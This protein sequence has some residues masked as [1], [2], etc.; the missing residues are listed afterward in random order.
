[1]PDGSES[2]SLPAEATQAGPPSWRVAADGNALGRPRSL[3]APPPDPA[4][5]LYYEGMAAYQ[6]RNWEQALDRFSRLKELQ[7]TRPGLDALLDEVR[8]FRQLQAAAPGAS[9]TAEPPAH[10][11]TP[12]N[13]RTP[14]RLKRWQTL[15]IV[16][17]AIVGIT[18]L[19]LIAFQGRL[20][21][22]TASQRE[23]QE[24]YNRGQSRL[25]VG[26]Y[27]GAQEAFK[28]VLELSPGD[29]EAQLGLVRA[30][31]QQALA[32][33]Y[34]AAE[35][36]IAEE[37]WD[38]AK[39]QLDKV[40]AIDAGYADA[41]AKAD[42]VAQRQRLAGLYADGSRLYDLGQW[43]EAIV[44]F[45]KI[46][47]LDASYR[48]EAVA[49]F[50]F[51][52]Y[53]NAGQM[54]IDEGNSDLPAV[55]RAADLFSRAVAIHP[56]NRMA[57]D[58][59]RLG[60]LYLDAVRALA[61]DNQADAQTQLAVLMAEAPTFAKGKAADLLYAS[62]LRSAEV[63]LQSGDIT[64][65]IKYYRQAQGVP[66]ADQS[67]A[68]QG[69]KLARSITPTPI[70][71]P[72][73]TPSPSPA[74]PPLATVRE[75]P[76]NLRAGPGTSF[77]VV[78][79][80]PSG[81][82]LTVL[83][84]TTN[85]SWLKVC[86]SPAGDEKACVNPV[87]G[88]Q[89]WLERKLIEA[90]GSLDAVAVVLPTPIAATP[91]RLPRPTATQPPK[92]ICLEGGIY[93]TAGGGPLQGWTLTLQGQNGTEQT[94]RSGSDGTYR[95]GDMAAGAYTISM[96]VEPEWRA[97]SPQESS[98]TVMP[99]ETCIRVDFWAERVTGGSAARPAP[100]PSTSEPPTSPPPT[101]PPPTPPR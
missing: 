18:A 66:V 42:F 3:S 65:A 80:I 97:V 37:D 22:A 52:S 2:S 11:R 78:T 21:W 94:T 24:I 96:Q 19:V 29:P 60:G 7:P 70:P 35:A 90:Q 45:E 93:N 75:G 40:L 86:L 4:E 32:Q 58:A 39:T 38:K 99:A 72:T 33:E 89:G 46:R 5:A 88:Q 81:T 23:A 48:A 47:E 43:E 101:S 71:T 67:A 41:Q 61:N 74:P 64:N 49:E 30:E 53:L 91:T 55:Q 63:A 31:R 8:W 20:P 13:S 6:H 14:L 17:L 87:T 51:V 44:Q 12:P 76:L 57:S 69:E 85:G 100:P 59:R 28:K 16:L 1:V 34:A 26:D 82:T 62:Q 95:F 56:R 92:G 36:A 15:G 98:V 25:S 77:S 79:Q 73:A 83:G 68:I 50:L 9:S 54:L 84:R 10:G 27:E